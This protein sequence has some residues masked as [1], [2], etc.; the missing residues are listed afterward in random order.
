GGAWSGGAG[1]FSP[2]ANTLNAVYTANAAEVAAG[3]V[4]LY[5]TSTGN[6]GCLSSRDSVRLDFT[7]APT[8]S[9]GL[10]A[11]ICANASQ[12][13]L[14]G[15]VTVANG[16]TWSGGAGNFLRTART[17]QASYDPAAL[18]LA[19]GQRALALR[20]T[21]DGDCAAVQDSMVISV[22]PV[23][24]VSAGPEQQ[25]CASIPNVQLNGFVGN[26]PGGQWSGG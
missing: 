7:P 22:D 5:L 23:P 18:E 2:N 8:I 16:G 17:P 25:I 4:W 10:D 24:V 15:S 9:G 12:V 26:A 19:A 11:N 14:A 21:G 1:S 6:G 3:S 13:Q 20:A